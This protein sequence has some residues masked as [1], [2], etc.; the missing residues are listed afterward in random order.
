[1]RFI[2]QASVL[3]L[4]LVAAGCGGGQPTPPP[5]TTAAPSA[6]PSAPPSA[7]PSSAASL[8]PSLSDAGVVGRVTITND[9]RAGRDGTHD[10]VGVAADGSSCGISFDGDYLVAVAWY[11][12]APE[13][14]LRQ[15]GV[16]VRIDD[17]PTDDGAVSSGITDGNVA[18]DFA[19]ANGIGTQYSANNVSD[20]RTSSTIDVTRRGA[21]LVF[22]YVGTTWDAIPFSGQ[23]VCADVDD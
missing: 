2:G 23:L 19:S 22:D 21:G 18:A 17:V 9:T 12:D 11:D 4:V 14:Q 6:T 5:A 16:S 13:G 3:L 15:M 8:D 10:I 20:E 7:S 1:M